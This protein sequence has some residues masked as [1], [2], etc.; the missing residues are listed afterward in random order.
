MEKIGKTI[1]AMFAAGCFWHVEEVFSKIS[2]VL[3]TEVGYTGGVTE[4]P[5]YEQVSSGK[6]GHAEAIQIVYDPEKITYEKLLDAFWNLH[7]P[8]TPNQQGAD[9]GTNYRSAIFYYSDSQKK[10]AIKSK[11]EVQK[12]Y[13]KPIV[14]E[15]TKA[16]GFYPAEE[17]HQ[18]YNLKH[19]RTCHI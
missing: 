16:N 8:T 17:Y 12:K 19:S 6:T 10:A 5:T 14:T 7:N 9:V 11:E 1:M 15:I 13:N 18:K 4:N 3:K 2:G